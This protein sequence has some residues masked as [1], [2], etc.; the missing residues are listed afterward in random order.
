MEKVV[1]KLSFDE[2][3]IE[4]KKSRKTKTPEE[5]LDILQYLREEYY[6]LKNENRK[7]LQRVYKIIKQA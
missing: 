4:D 5:R 2:S 3:E 1:K 7:G 6:I